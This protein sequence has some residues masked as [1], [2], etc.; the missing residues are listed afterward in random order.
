MMKQDWFDIALSRLPIIQFEDDLEQKILSP[1]SYF[2][3]HQTKWVLEFDLPLVDKK[4]INVYV[5]SDE[6]LVVEAKLRETY[7]DSKH[8][9]F[10]YEYFKKTISLPKNID[11]KNISARF[12]KGRLAITL[13]KLF[14]G[15]KIKVED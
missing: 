8:R 10:Q 11:V 12:T 6:T 3:E 5:S 1:L 14:Q 15:T 4:D 7:C 13:P 9:S 2:K